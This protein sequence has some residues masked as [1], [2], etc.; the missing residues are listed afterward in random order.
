MPEFIA[1]LATP[2]ST[3]APEGKIG[4]H[5][6]FALQDPKGAVILDNFTLHDA[7]LVA[8]ACQDPEIQLYNTVPAP[9]GPEEARR[10]VEKIS[11][12]IWAQGGASWAIRIPRDAALH[13]AGAVVLHAKAQQVAE[14]GYW[15]DPAWRGQG[16]MSAAVPL[17]LQAAFD[18]LGFECIT[19]LADPR[20]LPSIRVAWKSGF[21]FAGVMRG[22]GPA[23]PTRPTLQETLPPKQP[24]VLAPGANP[25][26]HTNPAPRSDRL[27]ATFLKGD[28]GAA[29]TP[30]EAVLALTQTSP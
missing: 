1:G 2:V 7:P 17:A 23:R 25:A 24:G 14:I 13:F 26:P 11:P 6:P 10:F 16:I 15:T 5:P 12:Q 19:W 29:R 20:N 18:R 21:A 9:Y 30:W 8:A 3:T 28:P 27:A 22:L 4:A